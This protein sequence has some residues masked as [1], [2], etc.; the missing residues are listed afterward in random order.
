MNTNFL[1]TPE[2]KTNFVNQQGFNANPILSGYADSA[3]KAADT[4]GLNYIRDNFDA[5]NF[6]NDTFNQGIY[7]AQKG[8]FG[9]YFQGIEQNKGDMFG[10]INFGNL[11]GEGLF[12]NSQNSSGTLFGQPDAGPKYD[13]GNKTITRFASDAE[14][15]AGIA[16]SNGYI[17]EKVTVAPAQFEAQQMGLYETITDAFKE[18]GMSSE[19]AKEALNRNLANIDSSTTAQLAN[20]DESEAATQDVIDS[21]YNTRKGLLGDDMQAITDALRDNNAL[22]MQAGTRGSGMQ[23]MMA[24]ASTMA[25]QQQQAVKDLS[26]IHI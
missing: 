10:D 17:T 20:L 5:N 15:E 23:G 2:R 19:A 3:F 9:N 25:A 12:G 21:Y 1:T 14:K 13:A 16:D 24:R 7:D 4:A 18:M 6:N 11:T 22:A 26:L 8:A